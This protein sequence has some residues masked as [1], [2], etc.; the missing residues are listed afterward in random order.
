[1]TSGEPPTK[2]RVS[3]TVLQLGRDT[4]T[5]ARLTKESMSLGECSHFQKVVH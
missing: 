2:C 1:M 3:D 4:R 5:T